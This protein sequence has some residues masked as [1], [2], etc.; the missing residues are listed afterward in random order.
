MQI[1]TQLHAKQCSCNA[2]FTLSFAI[3]LGGNA[4]D[5]SLSPKMCYYPE[6]YNADIATSFEEIC[7][8]I[9]VVI[10]KYSI[11]SQDSC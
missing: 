2:L 7:K 9:R 5:V 10:D 3:I 4:D 6:R 11:P 8:K 1:Q